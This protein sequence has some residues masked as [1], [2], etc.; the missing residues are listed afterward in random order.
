[1]FF[2][3]DD[4]CK[5]GNAEDCPSKEKCFRAKPGRPGFIY[6]VSLF[7]NGKDRG[8]VEFRPDCRQHHVFAFVYR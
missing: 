7:Y 1:M 5:C 2:D 4:I 8:Y 3:E 6:T